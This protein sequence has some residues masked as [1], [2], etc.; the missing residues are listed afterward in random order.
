M[1]TKAIN[2]RG[3]VLINVI[4][5]LMVMVFIAGAMIQMSLGRTAA[6][7]R[8]RTSVDTRS[9]AQSVRAMIEACLAGKAWSAT[10]P[11]CTGFSG[12]SSS[13][14]PNDLV[15]NAC[16][17]ATGVKATITMNPVSAGSGGLGLNYAFTVCWCPPTGATQDSPLIITCGPGAAPSGC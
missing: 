3:V 12:W 11:T 8:H 4:L 14:C 2:S 1:K 16:A 17:P 6:V 13:A 5:L 10:P 9:L 7:A 15:A